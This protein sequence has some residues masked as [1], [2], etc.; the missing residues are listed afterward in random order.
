MY[1]ERNSNKRRSQQSQMK[2][3]ITP[4]QPAVKE[5]LKVE[6]VFKSKGRVKVLKIL[7][8]QGELNIS[9]IAQ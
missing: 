9:A 2:T 7:A 4:I 8:H 3:G 5:N 1:R 6:D